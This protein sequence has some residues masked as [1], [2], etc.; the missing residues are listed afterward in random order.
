[1]SEPAANALV[2]PACG[3]PLAPEASA[4]RTR[5]GHCGTTS[6]IATEGTLRVAR[7]LAKAGITVSPQLM[8]MDQIEAEIVERDQAARA[9]QQTTLL[10]V[11]VALAVLGGV[12]LLSIAAGN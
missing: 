9:R 2:C 5:C 7:A 4:S 10:M 1:M 3:A 6:E 12:A 8:T 11:G